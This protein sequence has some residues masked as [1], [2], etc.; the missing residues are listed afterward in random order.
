MCCDFVDGECGHTMQQEPKLQ[1]WDGRLCFGHKNHEWTDWDYA[2]EGQ[3]TRRCMECE[4]VMV[5]YD[6]R[7]GVFSR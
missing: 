2:V 5:V 1:P 4:V 7:P 6:E 3:R